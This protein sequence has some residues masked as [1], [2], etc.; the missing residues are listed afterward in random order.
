[1][2]TRPW[3]A[4]E[5]FY[6]RIAQGTASLDDLQALPV[7]AVPDLNGENS[8]QCAT[9]VSQTLS[10]E[11]SI[12]RTV[13]I[14]GQEPNRLSELP[15]LQTK[16]EPSEVSQKPVLSSATPAKPEL[17]DAPSKFY[18]TKPQDS[19]QDFQ[20]N[21]GFRSLHLTRSHEL[22]EFSS[23]SEA[24]DVTNFPAVSEAP[25][26]LN[27]LGTSERV[28][29]PSERQFERRN[30]KIQLTYSGRHFWG[31]QKQRG[32]ETVQE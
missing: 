25:A 23:A 17:S 13:S 27:G 1:M 21:G 31:W 30:F 3:A 22:S 6:D 11:A 8:T 2:R 5:D 32:H 12:G 4:I 19:S 15:G 9:S 7:I 18:T 26:N 24:S 29:G 10:T 16:S 14:N 28:G 20:T